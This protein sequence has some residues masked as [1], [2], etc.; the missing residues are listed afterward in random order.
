MSNFRRM[1]NL[2]KGFFMLLCASLLMVHPKDGA[3]FVILILDLELLIH[4]I[5][6]IIYYFTMA[7]YMVGGI[8]T[9]YKSIII[10]DFGLFI[11]FMEDIPYRLMLMY[12]LAVM[13]MHS[14]TTILG[15]LEMKRMENHSWKVK[16]ANGVINISL[17]IFALFMFGSEQMVTIIFCIGLINTAF[18][19]IAVS[20]KKSAIIYIV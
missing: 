2:I 16:M 9:L 20:L 5:R 13:A 18:Y 3:V 7:R 17:V 14:I 19:N 4:G 15:S 10:I 8:M 12:L 6:M 1:Y 11:F